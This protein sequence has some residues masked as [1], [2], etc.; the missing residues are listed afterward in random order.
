MILDAYHNELTAEEWTESLMADSTYGVNIE[1][2]TSW[3]TGLSTVELLARC[4]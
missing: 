1:F 4:M 3:Y 2:S